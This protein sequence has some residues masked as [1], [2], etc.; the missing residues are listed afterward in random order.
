MISREA[1]ITLEK[2]I[3]LSLSQIYE[4]NTSTEIDFVKAK[5]GK[6]LKFS[7]KSDSRKIGRGNP[8]LARKKI[9]TIEEI[10]KKIDAL[11]N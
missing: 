2:G 9:T 8:L 10:D 1:E 6:S 7:K 11:Q 5:T 4:L 3:G